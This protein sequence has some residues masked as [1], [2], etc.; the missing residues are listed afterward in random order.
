MG[1]G[2]NEATVLIKGID[3]FIDWGLL[4]KGLGP[5]SDRRSKGCAGKALS[6]TPPSVSCEQSC[7]GNE[8]RTRSGSSIG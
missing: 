4:A 2:V 5:V 1:M 7:P 3:K 6:S 8:G